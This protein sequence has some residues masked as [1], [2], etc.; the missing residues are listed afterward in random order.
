MLSPLMV[1][2]RVPLN[3]GLASVIVDR[4]SDALTSALLGVLGLLVLP[5][6]WNT[7]LLIRVAGLLIGL[8]LVSLLLIERRQ[9][10]GMVERIGNNALTE[11]DSSA[12][13]R[14]APLGDTNNYSRAGTVRDWNGSPDGIPWIARTY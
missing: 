10:L 5:N 11:V 2:S 8:V 7:F 3:K 13:H 4:Y 12:D 1:R 6:K 9:I 14:V